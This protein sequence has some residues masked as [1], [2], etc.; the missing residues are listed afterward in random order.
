MPLIAE[1]ANALFHVHATT[2]NNGMI[3][4][5]PSETAFMANSH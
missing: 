5:R 3:Q 1:T 2:R 4:L